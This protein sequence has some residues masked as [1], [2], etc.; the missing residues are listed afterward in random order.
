M[1]PLT[2]ALAIVGVV[3][4]VKFIAE[5]FGYPVTG[6]VTFIVAAVVGA[7]ITYINLD[8]QVIQ[9]AYQGVIAVGGITV[10]QKIA[11]VAKK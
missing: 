8:S 3:Q 6:I 9:G 10:V 4:A 5:K 7:V 11:Q 2:P 1:E